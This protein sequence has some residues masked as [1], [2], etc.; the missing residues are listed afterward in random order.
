MRQVWQQHISVAAAV[1]CRKYLPPNDMAARKPALQ[2]P[3]NELLLSRR[4]LLHR[5]GIDLC[6]SIQNRHRRRRFEAAA[7]A[8]E[9]GAEQRR[10][11]KIGS[12]QISAA[13]VGAL[14]ISAPEARTS[15]VGALKVR[16]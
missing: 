13:K 7:L 11:A 15:Q 6:C 1:N 9:R 3:A 12:A 8:T 4:E 2:N 16:I 10:S 14:A 5:G